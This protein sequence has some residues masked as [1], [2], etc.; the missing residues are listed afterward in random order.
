MRNNIHEFTA[1][2]DRFVYTITTYGDTHERQE[3]RYVSRSRI[4]ISFTEAIDKLWGLHETHPPYGSIKNDGSIEDTRWVHHN[5][6]E[7]DAQRWYLPRL[8][9]VLGASEEESKT[10]SKMATHSRFAGCSCP[11]SPGWRAS[12]DLTQTI[13]RLMN[14]RFTDSG[15]HPAWAVSVQL[16]VGKSHEAQWNNCPHWNIRAL[17]VRTSPSQARSEDDV[18]TLS[19]LPWAKLPADVQLDVGGVLDRVGMPKEQS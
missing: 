2:D 4:Y 19:R 16:D 6:L 13:A 17:A 8:G 3:W 10:W 12:P 18:H 5:A 11:C 7:V 1:S 15:S 14:A 9:A